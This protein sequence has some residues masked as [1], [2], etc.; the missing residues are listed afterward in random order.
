[1]ISCS[2]DNQGKVTD[3]PTSGTIRVGID[4][5]YTLLAEAQVYAFEAFYRNAK[6]DTVFMNEADLI[7]AFM[8]D[9]LP[10]IMVS[11]KLTAP[12]EGY[13]KER[14]FNPRTTKVA[15]DAIAFILNRENS[16]SN[17]YY[18]NIREIFQGKVTRWE[19]IRPGSD[20]GKIQVVFDHFNSSN[21]RYLKEKFALDSFPAT[22]SAARNNR[23]VI[24]FVEKNRN[25]IGVI[26]VNWISDPQ[27]TVSHSFLKRFRVAGIAIEG[28]N[29]PN[30]SFYKPY[31]GYIYKGIYPFTRE[32]YLINRQTYSGL[33]YG[34]SA[35]VAGEKGQAIMLRSGMVPAAMPVRVV[36]IRN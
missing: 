28:D 30:T 25:A 8:N 31:Q 29:S 27:D 13:L 9:S 12:E 35:F 23:E 32:V 17:L 33:A 11:R 26:S 18:K 14:H 2:G 15:K 19:Q 20:L 34:F 3:S 6:L 7:N 5:A 4:H 22:C 21:P 36:E 16:D 24:D 10:L 1:M